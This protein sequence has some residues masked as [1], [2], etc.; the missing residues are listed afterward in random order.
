MINLSAVSLDHLV[1]E[2]EQLIWN[3]ETERLRR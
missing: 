3:F 1:G 2:R